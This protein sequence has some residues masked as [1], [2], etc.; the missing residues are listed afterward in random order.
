M[1]EVE[2]KEFETLSNI[3]ANPTNN[4]QYQKANQDLNTYTSD[5]SNWDKIQSVLELTQDTNSLFFAAIAL[6]NLFGDNWSKVPKEKKIE[7]KGY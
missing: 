2:L 5:L 3:I 6:K 7:L 1:N 4:Q